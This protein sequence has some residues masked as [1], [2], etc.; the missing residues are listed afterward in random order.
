MPVVGVVT[1]AGVFAPA[2]IE[3][4]LHGEEPVGT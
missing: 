4:L 1:Q 2:S 3:R